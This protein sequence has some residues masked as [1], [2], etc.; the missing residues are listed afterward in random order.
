[1]AITAKDVKDLRE[2]TG[3][4]M[5]KCKEALIEADGDMEKAIDYLREKGLAAASKKSSRIAAEGAV[6]TYQAN[7]KNVILEVNSE[8][9]F[10]A[11]NDKFMDFVNNLA[12]MIAEKTPSD[13][14]ALLKLEYEGTGRTVED[15]VHE[16][17]LTIGENIQIRR[18]DIVDGACAAYIHAGGSIG[19]LVSFDASAEAAGSEDFDIC[20]KD[21]AMQVAAMHPAYLSRETVPTDVIEHENSIVK[22]Q[23]MEDP[24][25]ANKPEA[26]IEKIAQGKLVKY[27]KENC[28]LEQAF[29]KDDKLDVKHYIDGVSKKLGSEI[30]ATGF[31]RYERGEGIEKKQDNFAEEIA[32]MVK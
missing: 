1:M 21:V 6:V 28:L 29:V 13:V 30:K 22:A 16:L 24:S 3:V 27:F 19:V 23:L 17:V 31:I 26:V 25:M 9:D 15:T 4:G 18:F 5:M 10:V 2:K 11:K 32:N 7:G 20:G 8:T 12:K 14:E